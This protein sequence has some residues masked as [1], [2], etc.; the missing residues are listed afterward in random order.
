MDGSDARRGNDHND[1]RKASKN[2]LDWSAVVA[3]PDSP[4]EVLLSVWEGFPILCT[5]FHLGYREHT[6]L[7]RRRY[8]VVMC[9]HLRSQ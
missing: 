2:N 3:C 4:P 6:H 1:R 5:L 7:G 8:W 9:M